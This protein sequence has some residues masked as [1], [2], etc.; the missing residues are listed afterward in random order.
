MHIIGFAGRSVSRLS[1][2]H[3]EMY[4]GGKVGQ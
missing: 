1:E 3:A 2:R 4:D